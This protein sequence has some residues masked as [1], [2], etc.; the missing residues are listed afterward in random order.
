MNLS[1]KVFDY[2]FKTTEQVLMVYCVEGFDIYI[3]NNRE[4]RL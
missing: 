4:M 3:Q 1:L 2:L